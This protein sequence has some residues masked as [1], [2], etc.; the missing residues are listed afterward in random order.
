MGL[1]LSD[2]RIKPWSYWQDFTVFII[3]K[4]K[5]LPLNQHLTVNVTKTRVLTHGNFL[6]RH[7]II[8]RRAV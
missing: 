5:Y 2:L 8:V 4:K 3:F 1:I 6:M 7:N